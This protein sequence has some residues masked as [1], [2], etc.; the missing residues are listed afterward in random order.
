MSLFLIMKPIFFF[1]DKFCILIVQRFPATFTNHFNIVVKF[2]VFDL[3]FVCYL[4]NHF[5]MK[6]QLKIKSKNHKPKLEI[7]TQIKFIH[8]RIIHKSWSVMEFRNVFFLGNQTIFIF[9]M[10]KKLK[11]FCKFFTSFQC[12]FSWF[13]CGS[14]DQNFEFFTVPNWHDINSI[15]WI[16]IDL[17]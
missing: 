6:K 11:L 9:S 14:C 8:A 5:R 3:S 16:M 1:G 2:H 17:K 10:N 15:V 13:E 7:K 4:V 12:T